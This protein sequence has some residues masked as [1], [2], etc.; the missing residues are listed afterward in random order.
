[1]CVDEYDV[2]RKGERYVSGLLYHLLVC[3]GEQLFAL[4]MTSLSS[5]V[6]YVFMYILYIPYTH[7]EHHTPHIIMHH[8]LYTIHIQHTLYTIFHI[9]YN[10][11]HTTYT[12]SL[13]RYC[14]SSSPSTH[15]LTSTPQINHLV[16]MTHFEIAV[17]LPPLCPLSPD[18]RDV[19][20]GRL[21]ENCANA[22]VSKGDFER[23]VR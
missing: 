7:H 17:S 23:G 13:T 2:V 19:D 3:N 11:Q 18:L 12:I 4:R 8:S 16:S 20:I 9:P 1:M 14:H 21:H 6:R 5:Q 10:I 22:L 15:L